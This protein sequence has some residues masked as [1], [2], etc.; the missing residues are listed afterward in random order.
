MVAQLRS[1]ALGQRRRRLG[2]EGALR[3]QKSEQ[4]DR[5]RPAGAI[6]DL[7]GEAETLLGQAGHMHALAPDL[8]STCG[9]A[10]TISVHARSVPAS[11]Y[12]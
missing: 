2:V 3:I 12:G 7:E 11:R 10:V 9:A 1:D 8:T 5:G 4:S 6:F